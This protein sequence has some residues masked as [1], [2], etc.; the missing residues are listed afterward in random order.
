[1]RVLFFQSIALGI[2]H[3]LNADRLGYKR[4]D[5]AKELRRSIEVTVGFETVV[6]PECSNRFAVQ[7]NGYAHEAELLL[8]Q[9]G[10]L[11][12]S[13]EEHRF[14]GH[15][16]YDNRFAALDDAAGNPFAEAEAAVDFGSSWT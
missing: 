12:G 16:W 14:A 10:A 7:Q 9:L 6:D 15:A 11:G 1:M 8:R 4:G 3:P 2:D 5:H 13:A